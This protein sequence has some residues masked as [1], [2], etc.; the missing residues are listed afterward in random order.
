MWKIENIWK[1]F[2]KGANKF[3]KKVEKVKIMNK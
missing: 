2:N 1:T 3:K